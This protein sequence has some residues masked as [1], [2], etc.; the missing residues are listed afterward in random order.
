MPHQGISTYF[1]L[2]TVSCNGLEFHRVKKVDLTFVQKDRNK[3]EKSSLCTMDDYLRSLRHCNDLRSALL[4][5]HL[6]KLI[7]DLNRMLPR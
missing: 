4:P 2:A 3:N 6:L 7:L 1:D 5:Y